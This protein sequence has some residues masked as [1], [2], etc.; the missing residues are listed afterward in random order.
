MFVKNFF[1]IIFILTMLSILTGCSKTIVEYVPQTVI[2]EVPI[3]IKM[4]IPE[5]TCEFSGTPEEVIDKLLKCLADHKK[6]LD[7][8]R[9]Q[10]QGVKNGK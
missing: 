10:N 8:L 7:T 5:I 4:D 1:L 6:V 3:P 9:Q 2:K